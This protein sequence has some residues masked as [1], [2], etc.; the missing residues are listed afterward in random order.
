M[1][2][3]G[4]ITRCVVPSRHGV[5]SFSS[6]C[7]AAWSRILSCDSA[8]RAMQRYSVVCS[9]RWRS[10]WTGR[11]QAPAGAS[12]HS[13]KLSRVPQ[14][15]GLLPADVCPPSRGLLRV[16]ARLPDRQL[17]GGEIGT[18]HVSSG[19]RWRALHR[20]PSRLEQPGHRHRE[21]V[22]WLTCPALPCAIAG[23]LDGA[24]QV[25]PGARP[26]RTPSQ[27]PGARSR[28]VRLSAAAGPGR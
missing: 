4:L 28:A 16:T 23:F 3:I 8:G 9:G 18:A 24:T 7:P 21:A 11:H 26:P 13:L 10:W 17:R 12:P 14:P 15:P 19:S 2:S 1:N 25:H 27:A 6:T 22:T 5:L 20:D